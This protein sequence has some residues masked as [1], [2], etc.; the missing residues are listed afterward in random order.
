MRRVFAFPLG[1]R[2]ALS[3]AMLVVAG[4]VLAVELPIA[5]QGVGPYYRLSLSQE[6]HTHSGHADLH[7][8]QVLNGAGIPVP[9]AWLPGELAPEQVFSQRLPVFAVPPAQTGQEG[10]ATVLS[11]RLGPDGSIQLAA[12]SGASAKP[13]SAGDWILDASGVKGAM[14]QLRLELAAGIN[15]LF[16]FTLQASDDL[17]QWRT[18]DARGPLA[19]LQAQ[20]M[21]IEKLAADLH[22]LRA[23]YLRL[24]FQMPTA[25]PRLLSAH[26]D[27]VQR[28]EVAPTLQWSAPI[29]P[30]RCEAYHCD[31]VLP[32]NTPADS[33]RIN[34]AQINTLTPIT[35]SGMRPAVV[36]R[37]HGHRN[38]LYVLRHK[39]DKPLPA[40]DTSLRW[41]ASTLA[42][43][44][45]SPQGA[46]TEEV[47]APDVPLDGG[48]YTV[49]RLAMPSPVQRLGATAPAISLGTYPRSLVF[50]AQGAG[51]FRLGWSSDTPS[52]VLPLK[53]L[54]PRYRSGQPVA[55]DEARLE[56]PAPALAPV[57]S[58]PATDAVAGA[59]PSKPLWL[60]ATLALALLLLAGMAWSLFHSMRQ[61]K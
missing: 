51:P 15:G 60:W 40:S 12:A 14:V 26:V 24:K 45:A 5:V 46:P 23:R 57:A 61:P 53:T 8:L 9:F 41:L 2:L 39:R 1:W 37:P 19:R 18:V 48:A 44:L 7:D 42:Y 54:V 6:I 36:P 10:S 17:Q 28:A 3:T 4:G 32:A 49:L 43:R 47:V 22:G 16:P 55:A 58:K 21:Q 27:S 38:P 25:M 13:S 56:L 29:L 35:V 59:T 33:L 50:L 34:L 20:G 11:L 52:A 31:Y 30:S